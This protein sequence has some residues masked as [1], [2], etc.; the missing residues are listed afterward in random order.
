M[1]KQVAEQYRRRV[2]FD[3]ISIWHLPIEEIA[4]VIGVSKRR[5]IAIRD[6][7]Y[8]LNDKAKLFCSDTG[9]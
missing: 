1:D 6:K 3:L 4:V 7:A 2:V 9:K 8:E 5:A